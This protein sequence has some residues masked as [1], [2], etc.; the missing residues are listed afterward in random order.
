MACTFLHLA[1]LHLGMRVTRF[2]EDAAKKLFEA[3]FQALENARAHAASRPTDFVLVAGDLFDDNSV[4]RTT[5]ERALKLLESF[6]CRVFVLPGNHDPLCGG[7]V[8][9]RA[10]W[11]RTNADNKVSVLRER[12]PIHVSP[13]VLLFPCPVTTKTS[14]HDPFNWVKQERNGIRIGVGHGS[15]MD[16]PQLP[17]DDH[18]IPTDTP[19]RR[20]LDYVALGHWHTER[21]FADG[22]MAYPGTH[23]QMRFSAATF[24]TGWEAQSST[25]L[26]EFAGA[27]LGN[28][29]H[30]SLAAPGA[31]PKVETITVGQLRWVDESR[32]ILKGE[33]LD[34]TFA[35]LAD[36]KSPE[37]T[38]LRL[39]L[40]GL[41]PMDKLATLEGMKAML[42]RYVWHE[43][44]DA[45]LSLAPS[46]NELAALSA[47]GVSGNVLSRIQAELANIAEGSRKELLE[48]ARLVFYRTAREVEQ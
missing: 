31:A 10:P 6:P 27:G 3:R 43:V 39:S 29:L 36:A 38:L 20:C 9:E 44:D 37:K 17:E 40:N 22:R 35:E 28:A 4:E 46:D 48:H 21:R 47:K 25:Q 5:S 18:P 30:V 26:E 7:S 34:R 11:S 23:E 13:E 12:I 15:V 1:D 42:S 2:N 24:A 45:G 33:D 41:L 16:R 32:A 14:L 19:A 8:W